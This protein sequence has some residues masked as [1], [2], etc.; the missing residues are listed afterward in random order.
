MDKTFK[1][2]ISDIK[3]GR[4]A[5]IGFTE[6]DLAKVKL[7][8]PEPIAPP[9]KDFNLNVPEEPSCVNAGVEAAKKILIDQLKKQP[10]VIEA[11]LVKGKIE[12]ALDHYEFIL[13]YYQKRV[14]FFTQSI[15]VIEPF[16]AQ[17]LYWTD[18][19]NRLLANEAKIIDT[20]LNNNSV[21]SAIKLALTAIKNLGDSSIISIVLDSSKLSSVA[22]NIVANVLS[23]NQTFKKYVAAR[24]LRIE[25]G[26]NREIAKDGATKALTQQIQNI[27]TLGSAISVQA[28]IKTACSKFSGQ[29]IPNFGDSELTP[30]SGFAVPARTL[31]FGVRLIDLNTTKATIPT[32]KADGSSEQVERNLLIRN[33][34]LIKNKPFDNTQGTYCES[35]VS[36]TGGNTRSN[37]ENVPGALYNKQP[38]GYAGLYKKLANPISLLFTPAERGLSVDPNQI[39]P[40]IKDIENAPVSIKEGQ[41]TLYVKSQAQYENFYNTLKDTLPVKIQKER[42]EVFPAQIAQ[43]ISAIEGIASQEVADF[44]RKTTD[45]PI[46]LVRPTSYRAGQST[47]FSQGEFQYS[48]LDTVVSGKLAYYIKA[49][50]QVKDII[51]RCRLDIANLEAIIKENSMDADLL[52]KKISDIPCFKEAAK[53]KLTDPTC[54]AKTLAKLGKDPL[55]I[56]TLDGTDASL[57]DMNNPCYWREFTKSLNKVSILPFPDLTSQLFR[58]YPINNII[59]TPLGI[60]MIPIPQRWINLFS[61][62][63]PLGTIVTFLTIPVAIV[64]IPLPS[65]YIFYFAP[66][67]RKYLLLAPNIPLLYPTNSLKY[68]FEVDDSPASQNPLGINPADP[69]KGQLVKGALSIP[70]TISANASKATRLAMI[71]AKVALGEPIPITNAAGLNIGTVDPVTYSQRYL[72]MTEKM[73]K[74]ADFDPAKDFEKQINEFRRSISKQFDRLGEMQIQAVSDLKE[75]TRRTRDEGVRAAEGESNLKT[76]REAKRAA[77]GVDPVSLNEKINS[78]LSDFEKYIDKI[79]LGTIKFP[80][81]PTKLNPKLPGAITGIQPIVEQAAKGALVK[82]KDSKDFLAKLRRVAAQIDVDA[83]KSKKIFN[84]TRSEEIAE[85]KDALKEYANEAIAYVTGEK[86]PVEQVDPNLSQ[87][88]KAAIAKAAALR[89]ARVKQAL[90]FTSLSLVAPKLKLFDPAAPCCS[91]D[92]DFEL[93]AISPQILAIIAVFNSLFDAILDGLT[94]ES[95]RGLLG[96]SLSN[97]SI[98]S[99]SSLFDSILGSL[100]PLVLPEKPDLLAISQAV[101]IPIMTALHI[102]QAPNPLGIPF[103]VQVS[104]PLDAIVKPILKAAIAYLLELILRLLSD[105]GSMLLSGAGSNS[106]NDAQEIINSIPCGDSQTATVTTTA[107]SNFVNI[108]LPGGISIKLPKIPMI[109][110]DIVSYFA[111][112]TSTDLV[113]LIRG[114]VFAALDGILK[115]LRD[116]IT[117]ILSLTRTLKDLSFNIIEAANPF[118]LPLK[119][120]IMA[121]QLQI[122]NSVKL[123]LASFDAIAAVKLAYLPVV[124][125]AEPVLTEVNYLAA[126]AA[127]AFGSRPGVQVARIAASPFFNQDD[128]PPWERLTHKNPLFAIF[129]DEIAWRTSLMSTGSLIFKTKMPGLFPTSLVVNVIVDT[130][131]HIG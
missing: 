39:D 24:A 90:A 13:K 121:I 48:T 128:L 71:A 123:R 74:G 15:T 122:P 89:K 64:G 32:I 33:N 109:P 42:E 124:R 96:E 131:K 95:L 103:P 57:P 27:P 65:V 99:I 84:L 25:A 70:L 55:F 49:A 94:V 40:L 30:V 72:S 127:C 34:P 78:V 28:T 19:Y 51:N 60:I 10:I 20:A 46:R 81:D 62:S 4:I 112:L 116:I 113:E 52:A 69:Y 68:G 102:P 91:T 98:T 77:R 23:N 16:T 76:K 50:D 87:E 56:R 82:D 129:L 38:N 120:A 18:E 41:L 93:T 22:G 101:M 97:I 73:L 37:Y 107:S 3:C 47:I 17:H 11:G 21:S 43:S 61:L 26:K 130:G 106:T 29:L 5:P 31:S 66:D 100:P 86:S 111:L 83:L 35:I 92:G 80:N 36:T 8:I 125:V 108:T 7:C 126:I 45:L 104:I 85:F 54:E 14:D 105:A 118:I 1:E 67:G 119:L 88:E 2:L 58:Y 59:P 63:T 53:T 110:L 115:P 9:T 75:K 117:P 6:E 12:E 79:K 114:L 44:F